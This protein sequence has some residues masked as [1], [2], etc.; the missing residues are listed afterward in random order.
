MAHYL[1]VKSERV[2]AGKRVLVRDTV[3]GQIYGGT[4]ARTLLGLPDGAGEIRVRPDKSKRFEV[5][6]QSNASNRK[7]RK[8]EFVLYM[9]KRP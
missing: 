2:Q 4:N 9:K 1:L 3:D 8:G 6:V 5:Y 7:V